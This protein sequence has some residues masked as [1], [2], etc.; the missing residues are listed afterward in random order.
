MFRYS[1][2]AK[3]RVYPTMPNVQAVIYVKNLQVQCS[4]T[5]VCCPP[6]WIVL[7]L[8]QK[9]NEYV[10]LEKYNVS[11]ILAVFFCGSLAVI[12]RYGC[13]YNH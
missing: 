9:P 11:S 12:V 1:K 8:T 4:P 3:I 13:E 2:I 5:L 10:V 6:I 7:Y